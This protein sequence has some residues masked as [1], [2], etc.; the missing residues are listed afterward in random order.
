MVES[1]SCT[2]LWYMEVLDLNVPRKLSYC[3]IS[4]I[5]Q[6]F[7][8]A[9][10]LCFIR[11]PRSVFCSV[12]FSDINVFCV[13]VLGLWSVTVHH[14]INAVGWPAMNQVIRTR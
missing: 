5:L 12:A 3:S 4:L 7:L 2:S 10:K 9:T 8:Y 13:F 1:C 11:E 14:V 6:Y